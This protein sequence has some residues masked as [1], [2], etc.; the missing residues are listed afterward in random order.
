M[1][2]RYNREQQALYKRLNKSKID[3]NNQEYRQEHKEEQR[4]RAAKWY[5]E[6]SEAVKHKTYVRRIGRAGWTLEMYRKRF[7]K[8]KG[9][10]AICGKIVKGKMFTDH[11]HIIPPIPRGLLCSPCNTGLGMFK[12]NP[13]ILA[14]AIKYLRR[15]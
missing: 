5:K 14:K 8:Q 15:F 1:H 12:D 3:K 11:K 7:K 10:C 9:R 4:I 13:S 2:P 6:N